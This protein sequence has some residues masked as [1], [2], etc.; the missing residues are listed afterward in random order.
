MMRWSVV[1]MGCVLGACSAGGGGSNASD[2]SG[3]T[4]DDTQTAGGDDSGGD[5]SSGTGGSGG[6]AASHTTGGGPAGQSGTAGSTSG[7]GGGTSGSG[8]SANAGGGSNAG[9][10]TGTGGGTDA[11]GCTTLAQPYPSGPYGGNKGQVYPDLKIQGYPSYDKA[12]QLQPFCLHDYYDPDGSKGSKLIFIDFSSLWCGDCRLESQELPSV[13]QQYHPKVSFVVL[14]VD[15]M[16]NGTPATQSDLNA[17]DQQYKLPLWTVIDPGRS[18]Y[19]YRGHSMPWGVIVNSHTMEVIET[20]PG[21]TSQLGSYF[22]QDM[23]KVP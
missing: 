6:T 7:L 9:G 3:E 21:Y 23:V 19:D 13:Y 12:G 2:Q 20:L 17:W 4:A 18:A 14:L 1:F 22:Q 8:G 16:A 5:P 15:G 11:D 10:S